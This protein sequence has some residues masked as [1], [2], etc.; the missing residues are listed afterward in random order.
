MQ[1]LAKFFILVSMVMV[2]RSMAA[3][4]VKA[5]IDAKQVLVQESFTLTIQVEGSE[6]MPRIHL[7]DFPQLA[8]LSGP[9]QSSNYSVINGKVSSKKSLSYTFV[10]LEPGRI[11]IPAL[12]VFLGNKTYRTQALSLEILAARSSRSKRGNSGQSVYVQAIPSKSSVY[13]G[14]PVSVRYKLFTKVGV[15]NYQ[16]DKLPN[17]VGFWAE[18]IP[19]ASQP[20]LVSEII[21]GV[22]YNTAVLK[23]VIYYPTRSGTLEIDPLKTELEIEVKSNQRSR[24]MFNDPFFNNSRKATKNFLSNPIKITVKELP[25]PRPANFSGAV[26]KFQIK[27]E[28]DT[29]AVFAN[30]AVGLS[31]TLKGSGNFNSLRLPEPDLPDGVD[32]FKPERTE[33]IKIRN[34]KHSGQKRSTYLLVPRE[35]GQLVIDP[36]EFTYFDLSARKYITRSSGEIKLTVYDAEGTQPVVTSGYSREEVELMQDDIRYIKAADNRFTQVEASPFTPGYWGAHVLGILAILGVFGYEH[37]THQLQSNTSLRR[38]VKAMA[39]ARKR[40]RNAQKLAEDSEELRALLHQTIVGFIAARLNTAEN[41]M[42]TIGFT[43][44]LRDK[45]ISENIILETEAFLEGLTMDRFAPGAVQRSAK[46]WITA[47][48]KLLQDLGKVL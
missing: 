19:Q 1:H 44:L 32:I 24:R 40:L 45:Q 39:Q 47:T 20:R 33:S 43:E 2:S 17:A 26:G 16:V 3:P 7:P 38:S 30:D 31:I 11:T 41:A 10:A 9:M 27:A 18:E 35:P 34:M 4:V 6:D 36:V 42:D 22:R 29:N 12:A 5:S 46:E 48:Q 14:E 13:L 15:Y 21:A 23:T 25:D 37:R 8:L 28:L